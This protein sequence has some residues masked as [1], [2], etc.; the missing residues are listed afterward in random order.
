MASAIN[1]EPHHT[2]RVLS[3]FDF[4]ET[5]L[6]HDYFEG[7]NKT[8]EGNKKSLGAVQLG[9]TIS[10]GRTKADDGSADSPAA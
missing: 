1:K 3:F 10:H 8:G 9:K 2:I 4:K 5:F 6:Q 7:A